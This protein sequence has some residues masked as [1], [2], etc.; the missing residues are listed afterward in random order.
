VPRRERRRSRVPCALAALALVAA[1]LPTSGVTLAGPVEAR[2][3]WKDAQALPRGAPWRERVAAWRAVRREAPRTDSILA[4]AAAAEARVLRERGFAPAAEA[5]EALGASLGTRSDP[6]RLARALAAAR[7]WI[8]AGTD[9][10]GA[11]G[12]RH[13]LDDVVE[14]AGAGAAGLAASALDLLARL[15]HEGG[16]LETLTRFV[17]RAEALVPGRLGTRLRLLDRV[18]VLLVARGAGAEARRV[19]SEQRRLYAQ[20]ERAGGE[21]AKDAAKA[22]LSLRLPDLLAEDG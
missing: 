5:L 1:A 13:L 21:T 14:N 11:A 16:D 6:D 12:A 8:D 4:R 17:R 18:G 9:G 2:A 22:W 3:R 20:A 7:E 15:A 10:G 19:G